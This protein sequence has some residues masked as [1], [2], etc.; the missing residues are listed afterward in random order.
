[1]NR[2]CEGSGKGLSTSLVPPHVPLHPTL[3][4]G[5]LHVRQRRPCCVAPCGRH[6]PPPPLTPPCA[7]TSMA[8]PCACGGLALLI[9]ALKA[10]GQ[11][12][13][14]A[15]IRRGP[16][17]G[18]GGGEGCRRA[19]VSKTG[20]GAAG[21]RIPQPPKLNLMP[22]A[23]TGPLPFPSLA[24]QAC[25]GEHLQAGGRGGARRCADLRPGAAAGARRGLTDACKAARLRAGPLAG[26]RAAP[27]AACVRHCATQ[28]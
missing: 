1:M 10:E 9:S 28:L 27:W 24:L 17:R 13:T 25:G 6:T 26:T 18:G 16:G 12:A 5:C 15:R 11:A 2:I 23:V 8:S 21:C 20:T 19:G 3:S 4:F 7:G 22:T 14:P